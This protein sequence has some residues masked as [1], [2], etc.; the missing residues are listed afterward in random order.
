MPALTS[1][2]P[3]GIGV[4]GQRKEAC[5]LPRKGLT[6]GHGWIFH[7]APLAGQAIAPGLGLPV[8]IVQ[9]R[10]GARGKERIAYVPDGALDAPFLISSSR[11]AW[12]RLEVVMPGKLD[13]GGIE[14][15]DVPVALEYG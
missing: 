2:L 9:I 6:H 1:T 12:A 13:D 3:D 5:T 14:A 11:V 10:E 7:S 15:D 8:Q 4:V